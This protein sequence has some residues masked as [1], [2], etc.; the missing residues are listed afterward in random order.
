MEVM[1]QWENPENELKEMGITQ[2]GVLFKMTKLIKDLQKEMK[3]MD[4]YERDK[5]TQLGM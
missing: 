4:I 1:L 2:R 3:P 5:I